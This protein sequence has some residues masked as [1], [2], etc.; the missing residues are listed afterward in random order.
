VSG[1]LRLPI[2]TPRLIL[3]RLGV[4]DLAA[5]AKYRH[6]PDVARYQSWEQWTLEDGKQLLQSQE[7]LAPG[8]PGAWFQFAVRLEPGGEL[9][10]DC[11][12]HV[13]AEDPRLGEIGFTF[14]RR[15]Q[16]RGLA[17]EATE[18]VLGFAFDGLQLHRIKAVVD[19]R[20]LP[21]VRLLERLGL[22][23]E[24]HHLQHAWFKGAWSDEYIYATRRAEWQA[25]HPPA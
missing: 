10:G 8:T 13:D 3:D 25:K 9:I 16:G 4:D 12:L 11:G 24:A 5:L 2:R 23:R 14:D 18:A 22:R 6:D 19:C 20:N 21:A 17:S 1:A 15:H 7:G